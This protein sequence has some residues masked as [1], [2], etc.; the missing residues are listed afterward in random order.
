VFGD[1]TGPD[2]IG[3]DEGFLAGFRGVDSIMP[4]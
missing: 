4:P 1:G 2:S 3:G